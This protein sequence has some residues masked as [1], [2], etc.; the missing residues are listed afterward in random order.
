MLVG[1]GECMV[2]I[3]PNGVS[4]YQLSFAGDTY[5]ACWTALIALRGAASVRYVTAIGTDWMSDMMFE[6]FERAGVETGFVRCMPDLTVGLYAIRV[7]DG[8]R[9]F[10]YWRRDSAATQSPFMSDRRAQRSR[11]LGGFERVGNLVGLEPDGFKHA[12]R[13]AR[14]RTSNSPVPE[15]TP[16]R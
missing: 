14:A 12:L 8:E 5:N 11:P 2:E 6:S 9:S 1:I 7:L 3:A 13:Q 16:P 15:A 10:A 4:A